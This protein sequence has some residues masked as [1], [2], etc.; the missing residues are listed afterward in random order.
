MQLLSLL[1][2]SVGLTLAVP[3][4][5]PAPV[6]S[7]KLCHCL[8]L[9]APVSIDRSA[10]QDG[11][12]QTPCYGPR[13]NKASPEAIQNLHRKANEMQNKTNLHKIQL[14][15]LLSNRSLVKQ[16]YFTL[17]VN[18][19]LEKNTI[20]IFFFFLKLEFCP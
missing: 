11:V 19:D 6:V 10:L 15:H 12:S 7:T 4:S 18:L 17:N 14:I 13:T 9:H 5:L 1:S 3:L 2:F 8:H 16:F 20:S